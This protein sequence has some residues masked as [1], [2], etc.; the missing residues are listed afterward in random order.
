M[1]L[2]L[3]CRRPTTCGTVARSPIWTAR[4]SPSR[5]LAQLEQLRRGAEEDRYEAALALGRHA[6]IVPELEALAAAEPLRERVAAQLVRAL[7]AAGRQA[8]ALSAFER[9]RS[10]LVE[11]LG[12]DPSP[13]LTAARQSVLLGPP[14]AA[15]PAASARTNLP[16]ALT[17]FVGR[18][19]ELGRIGQLLA[20]HRLVTLTGP[21]GAGKT[22][23]AIAAGARVT[24][25]T[26]GVWIVELAS[27]SDPDELASAAL[28]ALSTRETNLLDPSL[29]ASRDAHSRLVDMLAERRIV[30]VLDNCEHLVDAAAALADH[31]LARCPQLRILATSREPLSITGEAICPVLPLGLP[32]P[33]LAAPESLG[34]ASVRLFADRAAAVQPGFAVD[35][36]TVAPVVE[37]CRRLDGLPLAIELAAARLRTLPVQVVAARLNDRFRLL[38]GGSRTAVARHQTLRSVVAWSWELLT[39]DERRLAESLAVYHGGI[40]VESATAVSGL[41]EDDTLE[42]L[43]ALADKSIVQPVDG[44]ATGTRL[45]WRM[46][47]ILR[48]YGSEQLAAQHRTAQVRAAHAE[49]FCRLAERLEPTLRTSEQLRSVRQLAA[50]R[51]NLTAALRFSIDDGHTARAVRFGAAL[52]WYWHLVGGEAEAIGWLGQIIEMPR[53]GAGAGLSAVRRGM[54]VRRGRHR[55]RERARQATRSRAH[56]AGHAGSRERIA[57]PAR[58]AGAGDG[59]RARR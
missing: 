39:A 35:E 38:T 24:D 48:E 46:L 31:L 29:P 40:T 55:R 12:L 21:G 23:L 25:A 49:L 18:D 33:G 13:E 56:E 57:S 59:S 22:R 45:R 28:G 58:D 9:T 53:S 52:A 36:S 54:G 15:P 20:T 26:G 43:V 32:Q 1:L 41:G 16:T 5:M 10:V 7:S 37:I 8:D 27:V 11:Q 34:F 6:D 4:A 50:E 3:P 42:L 2:P 14:P 30:L 44:S 47:E 19:G 17:S 51:D